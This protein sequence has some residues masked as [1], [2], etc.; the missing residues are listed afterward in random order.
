[1]T[2]WNVNSIPTAIETT[3][4]DDD[5]KRLNDN[6]K[7]WTDVFRL[8]LPIFGV[9]GL[10]V[11]ICIMGSILVSHSA[12][13]TKR[14]YEN[15][16]EQLDRWYEGNADAIAFGHFYRENFPQAIPR[17]TNRPLAT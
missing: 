8:H 11:G 6:L 5:R 14:D 9:V 13:D 15:R 16:I 12:S 2:D 4:T 1:M 7:S 3:L 10:V 17:L